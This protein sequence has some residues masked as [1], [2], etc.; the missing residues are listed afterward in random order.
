MLKSLRELFR[1]R[2]SQEPHQLP[3]LSS[4]GSSETGL[5]LK[6][7]MLGHYTIDNLQEMSPDD[8]EFYITSLPGQIDAAIENYQNPAFQRDLSV[9]FVWGHNHDFGHFQLAGQMEDRHIEIIAA[10]ISEYGALSNELD[11]KAVLDIGCWTGGTSLLLAAMGA[12]VIAVEEVTKYAK[13][14]RIM[15]EAFGVANLNVMNR[16]LY[17]LDNPEFYD[18]F[19]L[20]LYAGV[21]YHVTDPVL[22]LRIVFNSLKD[23]GRCLLETMAIH[24]KRNLCEYSGAQET[25]GRKKNKEPRSG[26]NWF[27]PSPE[28]VRRMMS[29]VGFNVRKI[30]PHSG[31]RVLGWA[32]REQHVD[33]L[34]AGLSKP[35]IR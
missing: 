27:V 33:M 13:A 5:N 21:L 9:E 3:S 14:V 23:G 28:T 29:D 7:L 25:L 35:T 26:W 8:F 17:S 24:D 16:S 18:R 31:G 6:Q 11:G 1:G 30:N 2:R 12:E 20:V 22:S 19:D 15:K 34:R 32:T 4:Y 10:F